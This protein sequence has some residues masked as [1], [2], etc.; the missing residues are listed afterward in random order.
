MCWNTGLAF[1]SLVS[2]TK[3]HIDTFKASGDS[4]QDAKARRMQR[5]QVSEEM[6]RFSQRCDANYKLLIADAFKNDQ[7]FFPHFLDFRGRGYPIPQYLN[8]IG[9]DLCRGLMIFGQAKPLGRRGLVWLKIQL[10]NLYG[11]D[12]YDYSIL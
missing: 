1:P 10:A 4:V 3:K 7:V 12:K 5:K 11:A 6:N 8:H 9:N 2:G